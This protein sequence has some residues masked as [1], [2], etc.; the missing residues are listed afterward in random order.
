MKR[1]NDW[2]EELLR[3]VLSNAPITIFA[4]DSK[5]VFTLSEGKGL[6]RAGLKPG[7]NVGVS[8]LDLYASLTVI[9]PN[10]EI[11]TGSEA[12][13]RVMAGETITGITEL[14]GA[15]F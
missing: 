8:A 5:G 10:N 4:L 1:T 13:R 2:R 7:E 12:V 3:T 15:Y 6:E 11:I 9:L 14:R